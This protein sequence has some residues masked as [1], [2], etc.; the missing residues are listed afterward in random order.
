VQLLTEAA[1]L[2]DNR[3]RNVTVCRAEDGKVQ[4]TQN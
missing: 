4:V 3:S 2:V 1:T